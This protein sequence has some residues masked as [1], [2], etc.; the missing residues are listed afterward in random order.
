MRCSILYG[1]CTKYEHYIDNHAVPSS[2]EAQEFPAQL[3]VRYAMFQVRL[4][5]YFQPCAKSANPKF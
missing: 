4:V 3:N 2:V 5:I 1:T